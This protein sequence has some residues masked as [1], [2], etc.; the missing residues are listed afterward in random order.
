MATLLKVLNNLADI[1][2][3]GGVAL[4]VRTQGS[5]SRMIVAEELNRMPGRSYG[6]M[7][8]PPRTSCR[9]DRETLVAIR[10]EARGFRASGWRLVDLALRRLLAEIEVERMQKKIDATEAHSRIEEHLVRYQE[11]VARLITTT[12]QFDPETWTTIQREA[13]V[14]RV[15]TWR[16]VDLALRWLLAEIEN[17]RAQGKIDAKATEARMRPQ[18]RTE[19]QLVRLRV[20][21]RSAVH[22]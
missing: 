11:D 5:G 20:A 3:A 18:S 12:C 6:D 21:S 15:S 17:D 14:F 19:E 13:R 2:S 10:R 8:L 22:A 1:K 4:R 9:F 16:M 7:D